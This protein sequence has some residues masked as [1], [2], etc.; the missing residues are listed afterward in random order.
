MPITGTPVIL[1]LSFCPVIATFQHTGY[2]AYTHPWIWSMDH[3]WELGRE[4]SKAGDPLGKCIKVVR[5]ARSTISGGCRGPTGKRRPTPERALI[6][7]FN[8]IPAIICRVQ[9]IIHLS[10]FSRYLHVTVHGCGHN[11]YYHVS[12][13]LNQSI[14]ILWL[15]WK[16]TKQQY[17][18]V[19]Q[20]SA[21]R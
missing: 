4:G 8:L 1:Y 5:T 15:K 18:A 19:H 9:G 20:I 7:G 17:T 12:T 2:N 13:S 11:S 21:Q 3:S 16:R 6:M 10:F 14:S